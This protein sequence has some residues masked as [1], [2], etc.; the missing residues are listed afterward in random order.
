MN[1]LFIALSFSSLGIGVFFLNCWTDYG[2]QKRWHG[3]SI[4]PM[5]GGFLIA[6]PFWAVYQSIWTLL[7]VL[8]DYMWLKTLFLWLKGLAYGKKTPKTSNPP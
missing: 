2:Y 8:V 6:I 4:I 3:G 7:L 5:V 1:D